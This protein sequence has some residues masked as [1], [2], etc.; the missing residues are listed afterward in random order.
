[1]ATVLIDLDPGIEGDFAFIG[2]GAKGSAVA[3]IAIEAATDG[4]AAADES[5]RHHEIA[6]RKREIA[7]WV[8]PCSSIAR[9]MAF[10]IR[11]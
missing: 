7:H 3:M 4:K 5:A 1:M 2:G 6:P 9:R 10:R 11:G 8:P